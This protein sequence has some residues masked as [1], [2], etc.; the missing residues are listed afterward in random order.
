MKKL[1]SLLALLFV[2]AYMLQ[3]FYYVD[4]DNKCYIRVVP[5]ILPSNWSAK[6]IIGIL[7]ATSPEN[8]EYLCKNITSF[9]KNQSCGGADGGC[10]YSAS[11]KK[12]Y[13]GND[14]NNVVLT[15]AII[16]HELC[17]ARQAAEGRRMD[18]SEC[19]REGWDYLNGALQ[20]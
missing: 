2:I 9:D 20:Y 16:V 12:I 5:T 7:K 17:H 14:Q 10:F 13:I 6:E 18:E 15:A 4:L 1:F 3:A 8:Y 19:Y 11:K